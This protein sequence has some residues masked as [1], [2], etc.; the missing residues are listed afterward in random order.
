MSDLHNTILI[1]TGIVAALPLIRTA[2]YLCFGWLARKRQILARFDNKLIGY[3]TKTFCPESSFINTA[4]F[5]KDYNRRYGRRLFFF[6]V[7]LFAATVV[8]L[9]YLSA[10]WVLSHDWS[11]TSEGTAKISI[12]S[13]AGAYVWVTYDLIQRARQND[14]V[15][16]DINRSTLR[17][18]VSLPFGFAIS[19]FAGVLSG[20]SI[21]VSTGALA[22]FV[23]AFPTD[24]VLK[25]MRRTA[26]TPLK[27]D[28]DTGDASVQQLT[29]IE[30]ITVP[31]A[32]RFI[33]E[34]VKTNLQLAYADPIALTTRTGMDFGFILSCCGHAM[35]R[36]YFNDEQ[37][38][39]VEKYGLHTGF[40]MITLN[41]ALLSYD[42]IL[43]EAAQTG[44]IAKPRDTDQ[45]RAQQ[46]LE[47]FA[48]ALLLDTA[49]TRFIIDQIAEDPYVAFIW[50][51]WPDTQTG[52][53]APAETNVAAQTA[54][55]GE[56]PHEAVAP[57]TEQAAE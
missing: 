57:E 47:N 20:S 46:Q 55:P 17:L 24:T 45:A 7:L 10:S 6:P 13:L 42:K 54:A 2:H 21:T 32:E 31:I 53:P 26:A 35:V 43:D 51:M 41:K 56:P 11:S 52:A 40:E 27:L 34:G 4:A 49:S 38:K 23:G 30:G 37:M 9:S 28:A 25:F 22:F 44:A 15:T 8:F 19:A 29:K 48:A 36:T 18:L 33:D 5:E 16:S 50:W 14:I 39:V 1:S 12:F 3:Y